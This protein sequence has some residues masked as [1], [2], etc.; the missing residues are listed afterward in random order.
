MIK[1]S[2]E[3]VFSLLT[4]NIYIYSNDIKDELS[5]LLI[6]V[7]HFFC[8]ELNI[9]DV[10]NIKIEI[11]DLSPSNG[12]QLSSL[13]TNN[14][15]IIINK[16]CSLEK[17]ILAM[18]HELVH[19]KQINDGRLVQVGNMV[20]WSDV[21]GGQYEIFEQVEINQENYKD[22]VEE[23]KN[24]PWEKEAYEKMHVLVDCLNNNSKLYQKVLSLQ[25]TNY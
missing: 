16:N 3:E 11:N 4:E 1:P 18:A 5:D 19:V 24:Q 17:S 8:G 15:N 12:G 25:K 2:Y 20:L 9:E 6:G 13:G 14:F 22:V 23:Y 21:V 10:L 7:C